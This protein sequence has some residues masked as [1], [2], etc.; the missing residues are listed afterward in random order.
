MKSEKQEIQLDKRELMTY[1]LT[2]ILYC[3][4][5]ADGVFMK[6]DKSK[7]FHH[8]PKDIADAK[9]PKASET[10]MIYDG[11]SY[12]YYLK[13]IPNNFRQICK[14]IFHMISQGDAIFSTDTYSDKAIKSMECLHRGNTKKLIIHGGSTL[15]HA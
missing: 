5:T 12:F 9:A 7:S 10:L 1:P 13:E 3:I 14:K 2:H 11:S 6:M 4:G 15:K 8:L